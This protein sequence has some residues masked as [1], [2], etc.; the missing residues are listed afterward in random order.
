MTDSMF[1]LSSQ[2]VHDPPRRR[3][4]PLSLLSR[5]AEGSTKPLGPVFAGLPVAVYRSLPSGEVIAANPALA[6]LLGYRDASEVTSDVAEYAYLDPTARARWRKQIDADGHLDN[7]ESWMRTT[8][9]RIIHVSESAVRH[10]ATDGSIYYEGVLIDTTDAAVAELSRRR[11][12]AVIEDTADLVVLTDD[13]GS[14]LFRNRAVRELMVLDEEAAEETNVFDC[15]PSLADGS[16]DVFAAS[17]A[18]LVW[19]GPVEAVGTDGDVREVTV[20]VRMHAGAHGERYFSFVGHDVTEERRAARRLQSLIGAK[21][22]FVASISHEIR[23]PLTAV[24]VLAAELSDSYADF[25]ESD[26]REYLELLWEQATEVSAIVEDLLVAAR[27]DTGAIVL[28]SEPADLRV[29]VET[30][31]RGIPRS[32]VAAIEI[33]GEGT[34]LGDVRRIRQILR[35][36]VTNAIRYGGPTI[37]IEIDSDDRTTHVR[38]IDDGTGI[39]IGDWETI[40]EPF[41]SAHQPDGETNSVGLGLT[42]S[43]WLAR[44]MGGELSYAYSGESM[45]VCTLP[46]AP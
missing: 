3:H 33:E 42:I 29:A 37:R 45:F 1:R 14:I 23:T 4:W 8:D 15:F 38:V 26:R 11:L 7:F 2:S 40:F 39:S 22:Q 31:L 21:D 27:A 44:A 16:I 17:H 46:A 36:L 30:V 10:Q 41:A 35:N 5:R 28:A 34:A 13:T 6:R 9:G 24:V 18:G 12:A 20:S 25:D 32:K 19:A 43:R